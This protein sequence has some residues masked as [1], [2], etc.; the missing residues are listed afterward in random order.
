M[1]ILRLSPPPDGDGGA[2]GEE[3]RGGAE[4]GDEGEDP[5]GERGLGLHLMVVLMVG[6]EMIVVIIFLLVVRV[7]VLQQRLVRSQVLKLS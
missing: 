7:F 3:E 2:D 5:G 4:E 6:V 1:E